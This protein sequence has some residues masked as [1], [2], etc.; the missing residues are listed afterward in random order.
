MLFGCAAQAE[1]LE[2]DLLAELMVRENHSSENDF[3]SIRSAGPVP[4][5]EAHCCASRLGTVLH[6]P[7]I[8]SAL[9]IARYNW[10]AILSAL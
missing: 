10:R 4:G 9:K 6:L 2:A 3:L 7:P 1:A 8:I 5:P